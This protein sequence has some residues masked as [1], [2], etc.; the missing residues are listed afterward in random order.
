MVMRKNMVM[1]FF[2]IIF[3][4]VFILS[5]CGKIGNEDDENEYPNEVYLDDMKLKLLEDFDFM[6][7][8]LL[9]TYHYFGVI[10]RRTGIC[11]F[12]RATEARYIIINYPHSMADVASQAGIAFEDMPTLD[13]HVFF[14]ILRSHFF[15]DVPYIAH[16]N[17]LMFVQFNYYS[18]NWGN[19]QPGGTLPIHRPIVHVFNTPQAKDFYA[20]QTSLLYSL[21]NDDDEALLWFYFDVTADII[22][23]DALDVSNIA[24]FRHTGMTTDIIK[25]NS[26]AY[27]N[28]SPSFGMP[29]REGSVFLTNFY[30]TII[31]YDHLIIDIRGNGGG[32][33]DFWSMMIMLP[34]M[35][36]RGNLPVMPLY[37]L[38]KGNDRIRNIAEENIDHIRRSFQMG[39]ESNG[40]VSI[41]ELLNTNDLKYLN[42]DDLYH[43]EYGVRFNASIDYADRRR[44][45]PFSLLHFEIPHTPFNGQIW[46]LT[47]NRNFS[48]SSLFAL[49]AK[50]M[51]FATL[52]G[53]QVSTAQTSFT[54]NYILLPNTGIVLR[55]DTDYLVDQYGRALEEFPTEPHYYNREGMDALETVLAIINERG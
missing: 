55:W 33:I 18:R 10:Q 15:E 42:E 31:D 14:R 34:L 8:S 54:N 50:N 12:E 24:P 49:Y 51:D 41:E 44:M 22:D 37:A 38:V 52:V 2:F 9:E 26:I 4:Y 13:E 43:F 11:L 46:L 35:E 27:L 40:L 29:S 48:A 19:R 23:V 25:E 7:Q 39:V 28:I 32:F 16:L 53:E 17:L 36:D 1:G 20:N 30:S 6:F 45:T 5:S 21:L 47:C 3:L